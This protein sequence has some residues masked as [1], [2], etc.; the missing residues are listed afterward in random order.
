MLLA[1]PAPKRPVV[2]LCPLRYRNTGGG[3]DNVNGSG[4]WQ[5][6]GLLFL[7]AQIRQGL[8]RCVAGDTEAN[9][10]QQE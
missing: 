6:G 5:P 1:P 8:K 2:F 9:R 3:G 10:K 7:C 4:K